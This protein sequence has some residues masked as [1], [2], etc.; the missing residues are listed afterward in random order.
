MHRVLAGNLKE[1]DSLED[2]SVDGMMIIKWTLK[3]HNGMARR[4]FI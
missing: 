3:K 1:S 2:L 4:G